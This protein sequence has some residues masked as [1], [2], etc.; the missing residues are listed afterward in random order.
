[1]GNLSGKRTIRTIPWEYNRIGSLWFQTFQDKT[2]QSAY[3]T[4]V[5]K[6]KWS[7]E[8]ILL[9]SK[10]NKK[11]FPLTQ[12]STFLHEA[13]LQM[14]GYFYKALNDNKCDML[15]ISF[16]RNCAT[17]AIGTKVM[18]IRGKLSY[19]T[20]QDV[21][22]ISDLHEELVGNADE[23]FIPIDENHTVHLLG[24]TLSFQMEVNALKEQ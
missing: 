14:N 23:V 1:M 16:E 17:N 22:S 2:Y 13:Q 15:H 21:P 18:N 11:F 24:Q 7:N 12:S 4:F 20:T 10:P 9:D 6:M 19:P 3:C 8:N 5:W